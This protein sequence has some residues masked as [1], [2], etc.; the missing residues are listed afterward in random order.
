MIAVLE[1][2]VSDMYIVVS[3]FGRGFSESMYWRWV[4]YFVWIRSDSS[5]V[6][7][8]AVREVFARAFLAVLWAG[9]AESKSFPPY[10]RPRG[11]E[12]NTFSTAVYAFLLWRLDYQWAYLGRSI[13]VSYLGL[14]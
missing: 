10:T 14:L 7:V 11:K 9:Q 2:L 3:G 5:G 8:W 1:M 13:N 4:R 12:M 6:G